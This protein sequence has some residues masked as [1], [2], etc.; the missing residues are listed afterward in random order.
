MQNNSG[1]AT[2]VRIR[3]TMDDDGKKEQR[4][5]EIRKKGNPKD[6]NKITYVTSRGA[7]NRLLFVFHLH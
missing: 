7:N 3:Q 6:T 4:N 1:V 5:G 2:V